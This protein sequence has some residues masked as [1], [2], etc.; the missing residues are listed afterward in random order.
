MVIHCFHF[1]SV[2]SQL[3][4]NLCHKCLNT[5]FGIMKVQHSNAIKIINCFIFIWI[6]CIINL[7]SGG[8]GEASNH[9]LRR[10][11]FWLISFIARTSY[12]T[13][14]ILNFLTCKSG[15]KSGHA[16]VLEGVK[17]AWNHEGNF[18][19]WKYHIKVRC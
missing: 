1:S 2:P 18:I 7:G 10:P 14:L 13:S 17:L 15:I 5:H 11:A 16:Y 19:S 8:I 3:C 9:N 4:I 6:T 12:A